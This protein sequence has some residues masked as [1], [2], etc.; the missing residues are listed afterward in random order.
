VN[1]K[2]LEKLSQLLN[3]RSLA[4]RGL[5]DR[6]R[7]TTFALLGTTAAAG[8]GMVAI[9]SQQGWPILSPSPIP[10]V[11]AG[12]QAV[13]DALA[14]DGRGRPLARVASASQATQGPVGAAGGFPATTGVVNTVPGVAGDLQA[15]TPATG[16]DEA[17][18]GA[19][20]GGSQPASPNPTPAP[21]PAP[22]LTPSPGPVVVGGPGPVTSSPT[23]PS[24]STGETDKSKTKEPSTPSSP[25][26]EVVKKTTEPALPEAATAEAPPVTPPEPEESDAYDGHDYAYGDGHDYDY[27][28]AGWHDY[29]A[30]H[31]HHPW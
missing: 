29:G 2:L 9:F 23:P 20:G 30:G 25:S 5:I 26:G 10:N 27:G 22:E 3:W 15:S 1:P 17:P 8:L 14:L 19:P 24:S 18:P 28:D 6:M 13:H 7:T 21:E 16:V 31:S 12:R 11:P 4:G